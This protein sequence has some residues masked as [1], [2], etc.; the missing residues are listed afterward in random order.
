MPIGVHPKFCAQVLL[1]RQRSHLVHPAGRRPS[2]N[3]ANVSN[4]TSPTISVVVY[5]V[6]FVAAAVLRSYNLI[7]LEKRRVD[8][9]G[10]ES[11]AASKLPLA[12]AS[13]FAFLSFFWL[14]LFPFL[15]YFY[16]LLNG[17]CCVTWR[18]PIVLY[19]AKPRAV[20]T[21]FAYQ[22][23]W[24]LVAPEAVPMHYGQRQDTYVHCMSIR[25]IPLH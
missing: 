3:M 2:H 18:F 9:L 22:R 10:P 23:T 5:F 7:A 8:A 12:L 17:H 21:I 6:V 11:W 13:S 14:I 1:V 15:L 24:Y 4:S 20:S 25:C 16:A 19:D